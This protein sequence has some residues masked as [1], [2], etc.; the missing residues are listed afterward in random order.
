MRRVG[1]RVASSAGSPALRSTL[2]RSN[3]GVVIQTRLMGNDMSRCS[4]R[5]SHSITHT[6][7]LPIQFTGSHAHLRPAPVP[8]GLQAL[9]C[10]RIIHALL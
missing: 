1:S 8:N 7:R 9:L 10:V 5:V 6:T 2:P 3:L 4:Q